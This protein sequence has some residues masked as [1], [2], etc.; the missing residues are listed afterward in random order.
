MA[1][2]F[3]GVVELEVHV[4]VTVEE[5]AQEVVLL[6]VTV[7]GKEEV[8]RALPLVEIVGQAV[9]VGR[10]E[11]EL[12]DGRRGEEDV[13]IAL[14]LGVAEEVDLLLLNNGL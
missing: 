3:L 11:G 9:G 8:F 2:D 7:L 4:A 14:V 5:E 6:E 10:E 1:A 13:D 12:E